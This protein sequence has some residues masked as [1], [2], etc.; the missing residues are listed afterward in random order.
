MDKP[1]FLETPEFNEW[2][3]EK[4]KAFE[5]IQ[6]LKKGLD[7]ELTFKG[8]YNTKMKDKLINPKSF[9]GDCDLFLKNKGVNLSESEDGHPVSSIRIGPNIT[10]YGFKKLQDCESMANMLIKHGIDFT[11]DTRSKGARYE[12]HF[13]LKRSKI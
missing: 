2:L 1:L 8:L 6:L 3:S 11:F 7:F 5:G 10:S 12:Y 4:Q 9:I 13:I